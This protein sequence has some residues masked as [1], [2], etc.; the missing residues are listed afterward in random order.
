M[1]ICYISSGDLIRRKLTHG[2]KR[3]KTIFITSEDHIRLKTTLERLLFEDVK[4]YVSLGQLQSELDRAVILES[5]AIPLGVVTINSRVHLL[6]MDTGETEEW[7]LTMPEHAD[8]D[9][10][11]LSVLAPIGTAILGFSEGDE[12]EWETPGGTRRIK[13]FKVEGGAQSRFGI[14]A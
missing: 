9:G 3:G 12:I 13:M 14:A 8:P 7:V 5:W 11:R 10:H 1:K 2:T 4:S 6:D